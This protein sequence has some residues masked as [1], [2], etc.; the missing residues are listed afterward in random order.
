M[1]MSKEIDLKIQSGPCLVCGETDYPLSMG[2]PS[3]CPACDMGQDL[4]TRLALY[5]KRIKRLEKQVEYWQSA[6]KEMGG[7]IVDKSPPKKEE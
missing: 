1:K 5:R 4:K 3:I 7:E 6:F 2:G